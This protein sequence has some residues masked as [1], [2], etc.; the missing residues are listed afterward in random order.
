MLFLACLGGLVGFIFVV[1]GLSWKH[2]GPSW[3]WPKQV[4]QGQVKLGQVKAGQ[5]R[6][7]DPPGSGPRPGLG[8]KGFPGHIRM[9]LHWKTHP[10]QN[11]SGTRL[12]R[13]F[14]G[15]QTSR[16]RLGHVLG[17]LGSSWALLGQPRNVF[18]T[19]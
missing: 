18:K 12:G 17:G 2:L 8:R 16:G 3:A 14:S 6:F 11:K 10:V 19:S 4:K 1:S 13:N 15:L 7:G 5:D 9:G